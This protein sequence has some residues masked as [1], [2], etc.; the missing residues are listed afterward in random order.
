MF[1]EAMIIGL[2]FGKLRGGEIGNFKVGSIKGWMLMVLALLV[3]FSPLLLEDIQ[4]VQAG[5]PYTYIASL[6][7]LILFFIL[8]V[9]KKVFWIL[10]VGTFINLLVM[11]LYKNKMPIVAGGFHVNSII[12]YVPFEDLKTWTKFFGRWMVIPK[13]YFLPGIISIGDLLS[14]IGMFWLIQGIMLKNKFVGRK[15][16]TKRSKMIR[17]RYN[18]NK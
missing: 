13:L 5:L 12:Q 7:I 14:S 17:F 16:F 6:L 1:M 11:I 18:G 10:F 15:V 8:N 2:V 3:Q 9:D 4:W